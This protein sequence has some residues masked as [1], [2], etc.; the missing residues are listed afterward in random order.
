MYI[1]RSNSKA[2]GYIKDKI[3]KIIQGWKEKLLSRAGKENF[4]KA[5]AQAI[6]T[7][8]MSCFYLT[9]GFCDELRAMIA[10]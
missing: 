7:F 2:F 3:W 8:L 5:E 6:P 10:K 4:I 9:K 1:G